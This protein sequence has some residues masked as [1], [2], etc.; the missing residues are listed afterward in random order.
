ML[1]LEVIKIPFPPEDISKSETNFLQ[2]PPIP[3]LAIP[4]SYPVPTVITLEE[5]VE[6]N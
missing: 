2:A 1:L 4:K 5:T 3:V 6:T